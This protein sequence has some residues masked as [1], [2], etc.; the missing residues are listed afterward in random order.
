MYV[1]LFLLSSVF[2]IYEF[3]LIMQTLLGI[4]REHFRICHIWIGYILLYLLLVTENIFVNIP[5][6]NTITA[7]VGL[8]L[9]TLLY[10]ASWRK[11]MT[12]LVLSFVTMFMAESVLAGL[13]GFVG[14]DLFSVQ[15]YYSYAGTV[16]L[17]IVQFFV[18]L[19]IRNIS[20]VRN[21]A[22][23]PFAYWIV[24]VMLPIITTYLY[25]QISRQPAISR[26]DLIGCTIVI[27]AINIFVVFLYDLQL[28][29]LTVKKEKELLEIQNEAKRKQL[30]LM[31]ETEKTLKQQRHDFRN[32]LSS[33]A[34]Y[35]SR[36]DWV[37]ME[38]YLTEINFKMKERT[39]ILDTGNPSID[40]IINYKKQ[41]A[42]KQGIDM[43]ITMNVPTGL[44]ISAINITAILG[45]LLDNSMEAVSML[46][47][48]WISVHIFWTGNRLNIQVSN[49][50]DGQA[51]QE[52]GKYLTTKEE[53]TW[54]GY[55]LQNVKEAVEQYEGTMKIDAQPNL[56]SVQ[57]TLFV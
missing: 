27:F 39:E 42:D 5:I 8:M 6:V 48:R 43:D 56:F 25:I 19:L 17:P 34:Y 46:E 13:L 41:L 10:E 21:N 31:S 1:V 33:L 30:V 44:P 29:T 16:C 20:R 32:H 38:E 28:E 24:T 47:K 55:G 3:Y 2:Q 9:I 14:M 54:H 40:G 15:E 57:I 12:A 26:I 11:R 49:P 7:V 35:G 45:N 37:G 50:C 36:K 22:D 53:K 4:Y 51:V 52:K 23:V 18:V